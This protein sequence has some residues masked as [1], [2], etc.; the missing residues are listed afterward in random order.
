MLSA[1]AILA[2]ACGDLPEPQLGS[3]PSTPA[4]ETETAVADADGEVVS[5]PGGVGTDS[6]PRPE[7]YVAEVLVV[8]D[9]GV[10]AGPID[11]VA[12]LGEPFA[13]IPVSRAVDDYF[14]GLVIQVPDGRVLWLA[15][16]GSEPELVNGDADGSPVGRLLDVG[17]NDG[18]PEAVLAMGGGVLSRVQLVT[19]EQNP[20]TA[21][22]DGRT[23]VDL[24]ASNGIFA[25]TYVDAACGG[26]LLFTSHGELVEGASPAA[27]GDCTAPGRPA[28]DEVAFGPEG[29]AYVYTEV[30]Y[31]GDGVEARTT[32]VGRELSSRAE[33]FRV[34]VGA[35][36]DRIDSLTF[37]GRRVLFL[38]GS[39]SEGTRAELTMLEVSDPENVVALDQLVEVAVTRVGF[40]R[41]PLSVAAEGP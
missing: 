31:R 7:G 41:R 6:P 12:S 39:L 20:L 40:A 24:S 16:A 14:G 26:L 30:D 38:R 9:G 21:L 11:G 25:L 2:A 34:E 33:L 1:F 18:T 4:A 28:F 8:A 35:A 37:D 27:S 3:P 32:L 19:R 15:G 13:A 36:G 17:F 29:D 23:L 5:T 10:L 22:A